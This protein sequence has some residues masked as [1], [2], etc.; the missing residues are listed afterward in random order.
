MNSCPISRNIYHRNYPYPNSLFVVSN[1][2][3]MNLQTLTHYPR[4][5]TNIGWQPQIV[6]FQ[7]D[8]NIEPPP[9][10]SL[11]KNNP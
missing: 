9:Y 5:Q 6:P 11:E 2:D 1:N 3:C 8:S 10:S 7:G 4:N